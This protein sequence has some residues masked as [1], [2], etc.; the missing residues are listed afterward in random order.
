MLRGSHISRRAVNPPSRLL[1]DGVDRGAG[2][3][4]SALLGVFVPLEQ[5]VAQIS[6]IRGK[7]GLIK[8]PA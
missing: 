7:N 8:P 4:P 1:S 2:E 5:T 6:P 3:F